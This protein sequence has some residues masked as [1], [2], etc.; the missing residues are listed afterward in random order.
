M[1]KRYLVLI[2]VFSLV[3]SGC[4]TKNNE[5]TA[6][7]LASATGITWWDVKIP[8]GH[9]DDL[10]SLC[11][12]DSNGK[13]S[14]TPSISGLAEGENVKILIF[15]GEGKK[16]SYSIVCKGGTIIQADISIPKKFMDCKNGMQMAIGA[17]S[18]IKVGEFIIIKSIGN[19]IADGRSNLED[20]YED[21]I[22]LAL[23]FT[24]GK[25]IK[26]NK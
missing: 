5:L 17:G 18:T 23:T 21:E 7:E 1:K 12:Y 22:G 11:L 13:I 19:S 14:S 15:R 24:K 8:A 4:K 25:Y 26:P 6:S 10:L 3:L 16:I 20:L 2:A 9:E